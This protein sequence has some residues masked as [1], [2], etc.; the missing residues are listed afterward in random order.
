MPAAKPK[1]KE[2]AS[3]A[4]GQQQEVLSTEALSS[5]AASSFQRFQTAS[6][7]SSSLPQAAG[8]LARLARE[9]GPEKKNEARELEQ[10]QVKQKNQ[11]IDL[12]SE[13]SSDDDVIELEKLSDRVDNGRQII[14]PDDLHQHLIDRGVLRD[15]HGNGYCMPL[16]IQQCES[17]P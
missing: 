1:G 2:K 7:T 13:S 6:T 17:S 9:V 11:V 14:I 12:V 5:F 16:D 4:V 8:A 3:L 15:T 10:V